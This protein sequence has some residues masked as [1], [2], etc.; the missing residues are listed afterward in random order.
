MFEFGR[1]TTVFNL[2]GLSFIC[3]TE[4]WTTNV[5]D[6]NSTDE[7]GDIDTYDR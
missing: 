3:C 7:D 2:D 4:D 5:S 6:G 1:C